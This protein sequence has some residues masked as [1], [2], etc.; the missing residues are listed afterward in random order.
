MSRNCIILLKDLGFLPKEEDCDYI[1]VE[2]GAYY[3]AK[4]DI[5]MVCAIG[6][7]DSVSEEEKAYVLMHA[8]NK[9]VLNPIKDDSDS[10]H[11]VK[12]AKELGY[13]KIYLYGG[14]GERL[15]HELVNIRLTY[16]YPNQVELVNAGNRIRSYSKGT[17]TFTKGSYRYFSLFTLES[18]TVTLTGF[19]YPLYSRTLTC[20]DIYGVSN[21]IVRDEATLTV[22]QGIALIMQTK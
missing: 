1:G 9:E 6:D 7:F 16:L 20:R 13:E 18:C 19:K 3:L 22:E 5:P 14:I 10:E 21:E 15:D 8:R 11:A 4:N 2:S 17:Y 12:K